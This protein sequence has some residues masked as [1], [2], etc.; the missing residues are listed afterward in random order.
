MVASPIRQR[1][2]IRDTK[3]RSVEPEISYGEGFALLGD[4]L[5]DGELA[6]ATLREAAED[7]HDRMDVRGI[8]ERIAYDLIGDMFDWL[9]ES[10]PAMELPDAER[11]DD[12]RSWGRGGAWEV[13]GVSVDPDVHL[14]LAR[15]RRGFRAVG[16]VTLRYSKSGP[17]KPEVAD[18]QSALLWGYLSDT[19][20]GDALR[21]DP[22]LCVTLDLR[23]GVAHPAPGRAKTLVNQARA[24]CATLRERWPNIAPPDGA[25][26]GEAADVARQDVD[27]VVPF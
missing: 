25:V 23:A 18:W 17:L 5:A 4:M 10:R 20:E 9:A 16:V 26:V 11:Y 13:E 7:F 8:R 2:L 19:V 27:M 6:T 21:P 3:Y 12:S 15:A 22:G 24:A 1:T 14:R